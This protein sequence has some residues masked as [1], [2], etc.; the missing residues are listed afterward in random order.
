MKTNLPTNTHVS[1]LVGDF[2]NIV[3]KPVQMAG[4][5]F[6]ELDPE[7]QYRTCMK[8]DWMDC[9]CEWHVD[10]GHRGY[11]VWALLHKGAPHPKVP[12][13]YAAAPARDNANVA[14]APM[15]HVQQICEI[16]INLNAS[17]GEA[18]AEELA[19]EIPKA[20]STQTVRSS[21]AAGSALSG[22]IQEQLQETYARTKDQKV[23][24]EASCVLDAD[25]G[26]IFLFYPELF[27]R[28]QDIG[29]PR[30]A[31]IADAY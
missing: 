8:P 5:E 18:H 4:I 16:A 3:R 6:L 9:G 24:N 13:E 17:L 30:L 25:P 22:E 2:D 28:T 23:L 1:E 27:H 19:R 26:D 21:D 14:V 29:M 10:G 7:Q 31:F 11:K 12:A 20:G 15:D